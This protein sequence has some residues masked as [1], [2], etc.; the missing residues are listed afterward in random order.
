MTATTTPR[1]GTGTESP[2]R[3]ARHPVPRGGGE[4]AEEELPEQRGMTSS[5]A[6]GSWGQRFASSLGPEL[7]VGGRRS[8]G[9]RAP[10]LLRLQRRE[11]GAK[12]G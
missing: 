6:S 9:S 8:L 3:Q 12:S 7:W 11:H 10:L 1:V 5:R 2:N 4:R